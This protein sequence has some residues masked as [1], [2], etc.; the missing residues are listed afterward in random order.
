MP[1]QAS[2][3]RKPAAD[4]DEMSR[5]HKDFLG[6]IGSEDKRDI[7]I[8]FQAKVPPAA[9]L[10]SSTVQ[11]IVRPSLQTMTGQDEA[12]STSATRQYRGRPAG[13]LRAACRNAIRSDV[14]CGLEAPQDRCCQVESKELYQKKLSSAL[15]VLRGLFAKASECSCNGVRELPND[16]PGRPTFQ[17]IIRLCF[18]RSPTI[19]SRPW[20]LLR[21]PGGTLDGLWPMS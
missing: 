13:E 16:S 19:K 18:Y 8:M 20:E 14:G 12:G 3:Y 17:A 9:I 15:L 10:R 2:T 4:I 5:W 21:L 1:G 7:L 6:G 11:P